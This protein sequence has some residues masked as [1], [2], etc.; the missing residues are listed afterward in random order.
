VVEEAWSIGLV[1]EDSVVAT[2]VVAI[3]NVVVVV[4]RSIELVDEDCVVATVVVE[5]EA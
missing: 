2:E 3:A 1:D 5:E 4:A